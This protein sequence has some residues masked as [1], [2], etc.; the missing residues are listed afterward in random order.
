MSK[1]SIY[2][3]VNK[4][5]GKHDVKQMKRGLDALPGVI[6]VSVNESTNRVAV[7]FDTTG[8]Q[9]ARIGKQL[10]QMGYKILDQRL[11]NHVM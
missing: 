2:F 8:V 1:A 3:T 10:E 9:T 11:E 4:V 5:D 7:D 6:S